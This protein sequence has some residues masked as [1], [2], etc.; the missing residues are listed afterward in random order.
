MGSEEDAESAPTMAREFG[1]KIEKKRTYGELL[2]VREG[3]TRQK[4]QAGI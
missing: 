3:S 2:Q 4:T 1:S